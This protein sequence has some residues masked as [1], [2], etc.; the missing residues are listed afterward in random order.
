M[1][2]LNHLQF[3]SNY[4]IPE[5]NLKLDWSVDAIEGQI[6]SIQWAAANSLMDK[7]AYVVIRVCPRY[8]LQHAQLNQSK[9][10]SICVTLQLQS[11]FILATFHILSSS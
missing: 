6:Q 5:K 2:P 3:Q 8:R 1:G 7:C 10:L 11:I 9:G 4:K